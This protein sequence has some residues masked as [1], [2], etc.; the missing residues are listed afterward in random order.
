MLPSSVY[1]KFFTSQLCMINQLT[2]WKTEVL[3]LVLLMIFFNT[4]S[5]YQAKIE[6]NMILDCK[7]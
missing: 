1:D 6:I 3:I 7:K 2:P 4:L 5:A